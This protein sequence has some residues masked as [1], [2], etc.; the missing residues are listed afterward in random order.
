MNI[1]RTWSLF[2][3]ALSGSLLL[4]GCDQKGLPEW[5]GRLVGLFSEKTQQQSAGPQRPGPAVSFLVMK[6]QR[7][8]LTNELSGR[9]SAFRVAEIRPQVS[10]IIKERLFTEGTDVQAGDVLYQLDPSSFQAALD[11]AEANLLASKKAVDRAKAALRASQADIGRIKAKLDLAKADSK[12]Y[13]QSFKQKIVSAAQRDQAA[14]GAVVAE[15]ELASAQAQV[16]SSRSAIAAAQAAVQQAEAAVKTA[17]INLG[18]TKVTAPIS[19]RIGISHVTEGA[20]VTA[21]QPTPMAVIQQMDPI[22]ADVPQAATKLLALKKDRA[23]AEQ[24]ELDK[25]QLILEDGTPYPLEGTLQFSDVTVDP[26]TG[27]VTLRVVFPN[28]DRMLLPG[29][30]VRTVIQEGV[31]EQAI[32]IPQQGVS[33]NP[34]GDPYALVVNAESKAEYRPLV[35]ERAIKDK[36]LV[37]KGLAPGDKVIVEGLLMLRPGTVVTATPFG[38]KPQGPPQGGAAP[39]KEGGEGH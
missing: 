18:Y 11:N 38:E 8:V 21:Y 31:R 10:G 27:S 7:V 20:V 12:R 14:T 26:T 30:F 35:L 29:M 4:T 6:Q 36:W 16:E 28:P 37:T 25:V 23:V 13:E 9:T 1:L 32:L 19:G 22:Y 3:V 2:L 15:A 24:E 33:R 34:K 17:K 5:A 39:Q